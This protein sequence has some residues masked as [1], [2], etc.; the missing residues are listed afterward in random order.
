MNIIIITGQTATGKTKTALEIASLCNG[1]LINCDSRQIYKKLDIVT[2]KDI[3]DTN[4][5]VDRKVNG[6]DV[7][8]YKI[9]SQI[10]NIKFTSQISNPKSLF[11]NYQGK[12]ILNKSQTPNSKSLKANNQEPGT[13]NQQPISNLQSLS[14]PLWLYDV[15]DPKSYFSSYDYKVLALDVISDILKRGKTP[16]L[17]GG[18]G[19]YLY[20]LLY[21]IPTSGIPQNWKLR[22]ELAA[23][24]IEELQKKYELLNSSVYGKLNNS[25]KN[26]TQRLIRKI[27][28]A[29][30]EKENNIKFES[31][32]PTFSLLTSLHLPKKALKIHILLEDDKEQLK[33]NIEMRVNQRLDKG[34]VEEVKQLISS[35]YLKND[36]GLKTIGYA[37]LI[38]H[39][40]DKM[41]FE[42]AKQQWIT[43][44][45]QYAKRQA[46]FMK[47]YFTSAFL[48]HQEDF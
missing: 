1:E 45:V 14:L 30:Y 35:G 48:P 12:Q 5:I 17:V 6:F 2:G 16:I 7:G 24:K 25:E 4:F 47:K 27:E 18:A 11:K 23:T 36:P 28:I 22:D 41:S 3:T 43:K 34:A 20:H 13:N 10:S 40:E 26:N 38:S 32:N 44:E 8:Y 19:Y 31:L 33:H 39:L 15:V 37:Q 46:T 29:L 42:E 9:K 21:D